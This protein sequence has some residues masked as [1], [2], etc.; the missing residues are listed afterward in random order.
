MRLTSA[1]AESTGE[2][3]A[4]P[5]HATVHLRTRGE[6]V[7]FL[8][9]FT[10]ARGSPPLTRRARSLLRVRAH[11][12]RLGEHELEPGVFLIRRGSPPLTRRALERHVRPERVGRFANARTESMCAAVVGLGGSPVHLRSCGAHPLSPG[13]LDGAYGFLALVLEGDQKLSKSTGS[14]R[15]S[16]CYA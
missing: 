16:A 6:H 10:S 13:M 7:G 4:M 14:R 1:R 11:E 15:V 8:G 2:W 5:H 12:A 9:P 3:Q